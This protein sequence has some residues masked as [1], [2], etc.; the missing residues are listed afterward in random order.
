MSCSIKD[1]KKC[2]LGQL[3]AELWTIRTSSVTK[4]GMLHIVSLAWWKIN[5]FIFYFLKFD[6][7]WE[8]KANLRL[9]IVAFPFAAG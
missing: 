2:R 6:T 5:Y 3:L 4:W 9:L 8:K 1:P 7:L